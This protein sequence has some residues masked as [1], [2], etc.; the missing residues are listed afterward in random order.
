MSRYGSPDLKIEI[1]DGV[2]GAGELQDVSADILDF[3]G[4]DLEAVTE[5]SHGFG[6]DWVKHA[7]TGLSKGSDIT[8]K[9]FYDDTTSTGTDAL[10][11]RVGVQTELKVTWGGTKTTTV[12]VLIKSYKR[13]P[14]RGELTKFECVLMITGEPAEDEV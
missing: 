14:S 2:E 7:F 10:F 6:D 9:G 4:I 1:S 3:N 11:N 5:E 13:Q 8:I 12:D